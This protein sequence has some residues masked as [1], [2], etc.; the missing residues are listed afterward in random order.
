MKYYIILILLVAFAFANSIQNS[1][2]WDDYGLIVENPRIN[3]PLNEIPSIFIKPMW[4]MAGY[5]EYKQVYYRPMVSLL[6]VLNYKAWGLNP[7]GFHLINIFAH[8]IA[9]VIL[10]RTGL[11]LFADEKNKEL[12]SIIAASIFAVHPVHNESV[13]RA[14]SGEVIFGLFVILALYFYLRENKYLSLITFFLALLSKEP[15]VMFPFALLILTTHKKGIKKGLIEIIPYFALIGVYLILRVMTLDTVLGMK[16]SEPVFT[17]ILTM[18]VATLDYIRLLSIPYPLSLF[19]PARWYSSILEPKVIIAIMLLISIFYLL[20]KL[21]KDNIMLFLLS[22]PFIMLLPVI[23]RVNTFPAGQDLSSIA[24]R[25]LYVPAMLFSLF[26][27]AALIR[28]S[29]DK[30]KRYVLIGG[31]LITGIFSAI[32]VYANR[33]WTTNITLFEKIVEK[34]PNSLLGHFALGDAY[35]K[36]GL[37]DEAMRE[38]QIA[39]QLNPNQI[40]LFNAVGNI[41]FLRGD[42][43]KAINM[44]ET[45]LVKG[46]Q[47][48]E[49]YY[50]LALSLE[51][52]GKKD[53]ASVYYREFIKIAPAQYK[54]IVSELKI[55]LEN[56]K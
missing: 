55:R 15:A 11:F 47:T 36:A 6:F 21:R 14:A 39:L 38:W 10:Y 56:S 34:S 28:L 13:G 8:L 44:Y 33:I 49:L 32:T 12:I 7:T 41:Y 43:E 51:S 54:D 22:F 27:V 52:V 26:A 29:G 46:S 23:W 53:K 19:Y 40:E 17:R 20:F 2:V 16:V 24:E 18:A 4:K 50:N 5:T 45:A 9:V 37:L 3:L 1:F 35:R 25:F 30:G 31:I 42:Y 48:V